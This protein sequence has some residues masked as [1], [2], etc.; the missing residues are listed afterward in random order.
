MQI[1]S[2]YK[3]EEFGTGSVRDSREGKGRFDLLPCR[4]IARIARHFAAGGKHYGDR[5]W[6]KGQPLSRYMD[7][8][9]RHAFNHLEGRRDEDNLA[10]AAWNLLCLADTEARIAEGML[11][12]ELDDLPA[13]LPTKNELR[14][15]AGETVA[16]VTTAGGLPTICQCGN[17]ECKIGPYP[18]ADK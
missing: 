14:N 3:S 9:L 13:P 7:S 1:K 17:P 16:I 5:N 10:A 8:A 15:E 4:A 12:A 2:G 18:I 11:P 6:E